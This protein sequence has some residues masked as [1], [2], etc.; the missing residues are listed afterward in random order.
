WV[1]NELASQC[2]WNGV[3]P[4]FLEICRN[5]PKNSFHYV[6]KSFV[7]IRPV[8][9]R[10]TI[11]RQNFQ[12]IR[13]AP[14]NR[15]QYSGDYCGRSRLS[16]FHRAVHLTSA[17]SHCHYFR[18]RSIISLRQPRKPRLKLSRVERFFVDDHVERRLRRRVTAAA[19]LF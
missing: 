4:L 19:H 12:E 7:T 14:F 15:A 5:R 8:C 13:A 3:Y 16:T 10:L 2:P 6:R 11:S 18:R 17:V 9:D 1:S